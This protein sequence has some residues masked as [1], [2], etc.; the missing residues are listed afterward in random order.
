MKLLNIT[1]TVADADDPEAYSSIT[2]EKA[3][4]DRAMDRDS[5][6][7][8]PLL[9]EQHMKIVHGEMITHWLK[10]KEFDKEDKIISMCGDREKGYISA[11]ADLR[12]V[13]CPKCL[14]MYKEYKQQ[15]Q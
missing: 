14:E 15:K 11:C 4:S 10:S 7:P 13:N 1:V 8:I 2:F 3:D 6:N 9:V 12:Q 5:P